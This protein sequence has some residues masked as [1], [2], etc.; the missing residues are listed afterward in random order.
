MRRKQLTP[1]QEQV[2]AARRAARNETVDAMRDGRIIR[3]TTVPSGTAY[4]QQKRKRRKHKNKE[5]D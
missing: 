4:P 5:H 3:P 1:I 2:L